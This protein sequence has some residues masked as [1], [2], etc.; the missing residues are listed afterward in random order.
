[1]LQDKQVNARHGRDEEEIPPPPQRKEQ[2]HAKNLRKLP[3]EFI[4]LN[5]LKGYIHVTLIKSCNH[6]VCFWQ[7][8]KYR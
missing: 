5:F 2:L 6:L 3:Y 4:I 7:K 8:Y 1:M